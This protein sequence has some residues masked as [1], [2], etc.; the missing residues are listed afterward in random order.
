MGEKVRTKQAALIATENG[1]PTE[2]ST[3][4]TLRVTGGGPPFYKDND[5]KNVW[6]DKDDVIE[7]AKSPSMTKYNSTS[8]YSTRRKKIPKSNGAPPEDKP[9]DPSSDHG[10]GK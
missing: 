7:W 1:R 6:Y 8:E 10:E 3:L 2:E 5:G 9:T 4:N